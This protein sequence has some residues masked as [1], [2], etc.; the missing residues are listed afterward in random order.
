M[1]EEANSFLEKFPEL[2]SGFGSQLRQGRIW[3]EE[4][5]LQ[6]MNSFYKCASQM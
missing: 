1:Y 2:K 6:V 5:V 4:K 3:N